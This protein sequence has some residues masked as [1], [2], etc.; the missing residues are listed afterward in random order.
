[1]TMWAH[2]HVDAAMAQAK[3]NSLCH[4]L[5]KRSRIG[6]INSREHKKFP[7]SRNLIGNVA[8]RIQAT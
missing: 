1:M 4:H 5:H 7:S 2:H 3:Q 8:A 6:E